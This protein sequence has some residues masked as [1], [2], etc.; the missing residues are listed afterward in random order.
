MLC[1][2]WID[3]TTAKP[4]I[5]RRLINCLSV[6]LSVYVSLVEINRVIPYF[7]QKVNF[8]IWPPAQVGITGQVRS[9]LVILDIIRSGAARQTFW[10]QLQ[11]KMVITIDDSKIVLLLGIYAITKGCFTTK[12]IVA[13]LFKW[14]EQFDNFPIFFLKRVNHVLNTFL[15]QS[16]VYH[17]SI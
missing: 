3:V 13:N 5:W 10:Y 6:C 11:C 4:I 12:I 2:C 15:C 7:D 8:K 9:T 14:Y 16:S 17:I 1:F